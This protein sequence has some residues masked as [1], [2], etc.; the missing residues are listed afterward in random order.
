MDERE[1]RIRASLKDKKRI[2]VKIGSSSLMHPESGAL[3]LGKVERLVRQLTDLR[4]MGKDVVLVSS[5]AIA[6]GRKALNMRKNPERVCAKQA[7]ASVGQAQLMM[8]YQKLFS[9][10]NQPTGQILMTKYTILNPTACRNAC[11]TFD[12]LFR[13]GIIPIVNENDTISTYEIHFGDNDTLSALVASMTNA[14]L[15]IM[16]SDIN[17]FYTNN[18][19]EDMDAQLI[20]FVDRMDDRLKEMAKPNTGSSVGTGGMKTKITAA[21]IAS[22]SGADTVLANAA[23]FSIIG[24]ILTGEPIGTVFAAH[25]E[26]SFDIVEYLKETSDDRDAPAYPE[27]I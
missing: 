1:Q 3:N 2:V 4:N 14:D 18:P 19:R 27:L 11:N 21:S 8:N 17:G 12:E 22:R 26:E 9:E 16:L 7:C 20:T 6:V 25:K 23:D 15:L 10:Y 24:Q 13:M 5:G